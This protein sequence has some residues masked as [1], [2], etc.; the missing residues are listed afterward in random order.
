M[1]QL[2]Y[3]NLP[4]GDSEWHVAQTLFLIVAIVLHASFLFISFVPMC[5]EEGCRTATKC[6][7]FDEI[8]VQIGI[9]DT[10][11]NLW[12]TVPISHVCSYMYI[13]I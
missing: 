9:E 10:S 3:C 7:Q 12:S 11:V 13:A 2:P 1:F 5:F 8:I 4:Q 6:Q